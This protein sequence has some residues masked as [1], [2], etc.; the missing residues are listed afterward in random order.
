MD[1]RTLLAAVLGVAL[2]LVLLAF[3]SAVIRMHTA[4]RTPHDRRGEYGAESL[5]PTRWRRI[6][7]G[8]GVAVLLLG[9]Y[10][11]VTLLP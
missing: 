10:F 4:G 9:I 3:P 5:P 8:I 7:R 2:G 11:G 1:I 6:V